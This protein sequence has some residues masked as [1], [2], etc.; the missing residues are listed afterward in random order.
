MTLFAILAA[1]ALTVY[2]LGFI[3]FGGNG[4]GGITAAAGTVINY[5]VPPS[6]GGVTRI[7]TLIYTAAG[8]AHNLTFQRTLGRC[9]CVTTVAA[10]GTVIVLNKDPGAP[11]VAYGGVNDPTAVNDLIAVRETDGITRL[12]TVS[13]I[14]GLSVTV[15]PALV[16]GVTSSSSGSSDVWL[17]GQPGDT[18]G[19]SGRAHP[20]FPS[21]TAGTTWQDTA[22]GGVVA[23]YGVDE[24]ILVSSNNVTAAGTITQLNWAYSIS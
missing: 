2:L 10:G 1:A 12:Y 7:T 14:A 4:D 13:A 18:D 24:P 6:R 3:A 19:R 17:L 8:T 9:L 23:T 20:K 5:L 15:S 11:G 21:G 16:V 22:G